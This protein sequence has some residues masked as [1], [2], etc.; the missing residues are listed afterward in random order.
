MAHAG[1][2]LPPAGGG[3]SWLTWCSA[4]GAPGDSA[5]DSSAQ[6]GL[7]L[8]PIPAVALVVVGAASWSWHAGVCVGPSGVRCQL[9][10][11][12]GVRQLA[13][14]SKFMILLVF[15]AHKLYC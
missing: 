15:S 6:G 12:L 1:T 10:V 9:S 3:D 7:L 4:L 5:A 14:V 13:A 8:F 2:R 11:W